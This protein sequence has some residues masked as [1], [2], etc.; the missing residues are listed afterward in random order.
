[1]AIRVP[2][3]RLIDENGDM[4]GI[5]DTD[6]ARRRAD[7]A[8]MDLV[9]VTPD[10]DPPICKII[11]YGRYKYDLSKK[12][13][14][15]KARTKGHEM[16][17]V[18]LGRS[19]KIDPHDVEI[20]VN[21]AHK[22]LVDGHKVQIVQNFR[23]REMVHKERGY[24]RM[25]SIIERLEEVAK[26]ET[27]PRMFGR[28]MTMILAPDKIKIE[29]YKRQLAKANPPPPPDAKA[30]E[31]LNSAPDQSPAPEPVLEVNDPPL[32]NTAPAPIESVESM[33]EK[34]SAGTTE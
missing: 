30:K 1:M 31:K 27:P 6:E 3:V 25:K 29:K 13:R 9:E 16:K 23:G 28:R 17:E 24:D 4:A 19:M 8:G 18:R 22:F 15:T 12:E 7:D 34:S 20:R 10:S 11:D 14:A 32:D 5:V 21:Q 2:N 33:S 26:L